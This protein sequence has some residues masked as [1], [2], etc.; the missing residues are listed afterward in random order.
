MKR[1][2]DKI[3]LME[4]GNNAKFPY[5]NSLYIDGTEKVLIDT[6]A[7]YEAFSNFPCDEVELVLNT[8]YH[9]DH[10]RGNQLFHN[11]NIMIHNLDKPPIENQLYFSQ[12]SGY[13]LLP[14][15]KEQAIIQMVHYIP[16]KIDSTFTDNEMISINHLEIMVI[17][18]PGHTPGHCCFYI[19]KYELLFSGDIDLTSFGPWYANA[20]SDIDTYI[21]SIDLLID[22]NPK[23]IISGHGVVVRGKQ[24]K[25]SLIK[26]RNVIFDRD[27]RILR[28]LSHPV[29]IEWLVDQ[30]LIYGK[31]PKPYWPF[32]FWE[33]QMLIQHL[34]KLI[35]ENII[36]QKD[37]LFYKAI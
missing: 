29:S 6:G 36:V 14:S 4:G 34:N 1:I 32:K 28:T 3:Y 24:V 23:V 31:H 30:K 37:N 12:Y 26:Y 11:A 2:F 7:G 33:E 17:H 10:V 18:A 9:P 8:H 27:E 16:H 35:R 25:D 21:N 22:L 20:K 5:S 19:P 13:N 15:E